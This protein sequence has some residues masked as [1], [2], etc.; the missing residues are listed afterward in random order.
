MS[1]G[2]LDSNGI[3]IASGLHV[4]REVEETLTF[5][6]QHRPV[7]SL[8]R[9]LSAP[10]S[11]KISRTTD[12]LAHLL[13]YDTDPFNRW[14]AARSMALDAVA[15]GRT[16]DAALNDGLRAVLLDEA[17]DPAFRALCLALP[18]DEDIA[19][20]VWGLGRAVDPGA[21]HKGRLALATSVAEAL[22]TDLLST[23]DA[24]ANTGPYTPD[25]DAAGQ[26]ALRLECLGLLTLAN[27]ER[28]M[29]EAL[30]AGA[31]NMTEQAR[32]LALLVRS[33]RA[34]E[35]LAAFETRWA[36][37]ENVM[38]TWFSIQASAAPFESAAERV[39]A[40]TTHPAFHWK[41]PN[42]FRSLIG[43]FTT[44]AAGF[45][46]DDGVEY[47]LLADWLLKLDTANPQTSAR[48]AGAFE[49]W[50]RLDTNRQNLISAELDRIAS[51]PSLSRDLSEIIGRMRA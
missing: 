44:N 21:L 12:D 13:A 36:A 6:L 3:E 39:E 46:R 27:P 41:T 9:G 43:A 30:F 17:L 51:T 14:E 15:E 25:A 4:I 1:Y 50:R 7:P 26:R 40:L 23:F 28:G 5:P 34:E 32:A 2:L 38:D 18:G 16:H 49:T 31:D 33:G 45:H 37:D 20:H 11:V 24:M 35:H 47:R 19:A 48:L 29:A 22:E 10:V 8:F 42:R